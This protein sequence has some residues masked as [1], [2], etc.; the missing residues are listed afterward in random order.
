[1]HKRNFEA[2]TNLLALKKSAIQVCGQEFIDS[3]T[4]KGIYAKDIGFWLEVNKQL[5]ISDDAYE[6]RKAEE[7]AKREQ[8]MLEKRLKVSTNR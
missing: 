6:V 1:M 2:S 7:E 8:E 4:K 3:L 5:N